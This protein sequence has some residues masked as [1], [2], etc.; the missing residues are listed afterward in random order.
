MNYL[1]TTYKIQDIIFDVRGNGGGFTNLAFT[2]AC[3]VGGKRNYFNAT[4]DPNGN[5]CNPDLY[6]ADYPYVVPEEMEKV[7]P[8]SVLKGTPKRTANV[9]II[10]DINAASVGDVFPNQFIGDK[11]DGELGNYTKAFIVGNI[12]GRLSGYLGPESFTPVKTPDEAAIYYN[13]DIYGK[14]SIPPFSFRQDSNNSLLYAN[15]EKSISYFQKETNP[16]VL[17]PH[18]FSVVY[19]DMGYLPPT[20]KYLNNIQPNKDEPSTWQDSYFE[21]AIRIIRKCKPAIPKAYKY[22][23]IGNDKPISFFQKVY[24]YEKPR[25]HKIIDQYTVGGGDAKELYNS[26]MNKKTTKCV[27]CYNVVLKDSDVATKSLT[28]SKYYAEKTYLD[29]PTA[30]DNELRKYSIITRIPEF[31]DKNY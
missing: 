11:G 2:V 25:E 3:S 21:N 14:Y 29:N 8:N 19:S 12:D 4:I 26:N 1:I 16:S 24:Q 20:I 5:P 13:S 28:L 23:Q 10:D 27:K 6:R 15:T 31:I 30:L 17:I 18:D 7:I 22:I 9:I